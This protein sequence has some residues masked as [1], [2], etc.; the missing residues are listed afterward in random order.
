MARSA[1]LCWGLVVALAS[2]A[3]A[4]AVYD[5]A[6]ALPPAPLEALQVS[7]FHLPLPALVAGSAPSFFFTLAFGILIGIAAVPATATRHCLTWIAIACVLESSQWPAAAT[8]AASWLG[9]LLP[10]SVWRMT[11]T[12]WTAGTF[13]VSDLAATLAGGALALLLTRRFAKGALR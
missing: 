2:L 11:A 8:S 12:Y 5:L 1:A 9:G 4:V 13:D 6:R 10:G 7:D 3:A